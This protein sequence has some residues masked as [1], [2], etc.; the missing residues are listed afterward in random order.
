VTVLLW[1][2]RRLIQRSVG[3]TN[4]RPSTWD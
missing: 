1:S 3:F 2:T 4:R